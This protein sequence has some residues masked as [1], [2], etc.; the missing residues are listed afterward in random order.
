M[1][2]NCPSCQPQPV[3][4]RQMQHKDH[5]CKDH[6][7]VTHYLC[8]AAQVR[9]QGQ[10][11]WVAAIISVLF[12][13]FSGGTVAPI[14][15]GRVTGPLANDLIVPYCVVAWYITHHFGGFFYKV[16]QKPDCAASEAA[17]RI[18]G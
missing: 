14:L 5:K 1:Y 17:S 8:L 7:P 10:Q 6:A 18:C 11:Y 13:C 16:R 15:I 9:A 2:A 3:A 4:M 12:A